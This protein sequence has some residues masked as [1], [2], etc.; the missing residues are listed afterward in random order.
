[1]VRFFNAVGIDE[2]FKGVDINSAG[3]FQGREAIIILVLT[4]NEVTGRKFVGN[5][6]RICVGL[7]KQG[8]EI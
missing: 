1:M 5:S 2:W 6:H 7:T 8:R 3:T 4:V